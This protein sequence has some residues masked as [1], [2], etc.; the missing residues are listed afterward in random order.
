MLNNIVKYDNICITYQQ[1]MGF[2]MQKVIKLMSHIRHYVHPHKNLDI[3]AELTYPVFILS[4]D[5]IY[6]QV[7]ALIEPSRYDLDKLAI[8]YSISFARCKVNIVSYIEYDSML[9]RDDE[10][11]DRFDIKKNKWPFTC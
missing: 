2:D 1:T 6:M 7:Y 9:I 11:Y 5:G 10:I 8:E 3:N 4:K